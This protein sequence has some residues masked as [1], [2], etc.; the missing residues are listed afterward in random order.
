VIQ[1]IKKFII[2]VIGITVI[3]IGVVM[4]VLP[5]P[6]IIII[7]AGLAILATEFLWAR[8][9]LNKMKE[10]ASRLG[11]VVKSKSHS[12]VEEKDALDGTK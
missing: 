8:K 4:I 11:S 6:A 9:L 2:F 5:G 12:K 10:Q 7:P 1:T 3:L